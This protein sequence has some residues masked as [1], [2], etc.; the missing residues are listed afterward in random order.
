MRLRYLAGL[1]LMAAFHMSA[2]NRMTGINV[3]LNTSPTAGIL[4]ALGT[5]GNVRDVV[6]EINAVTLQARD[7]ELAALP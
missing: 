4:A 2:Q 5:H 1:A 7:S 6:L 3:V